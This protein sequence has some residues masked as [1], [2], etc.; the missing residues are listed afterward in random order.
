MNT[1]VCHK[2]DAYEI[3]FTPEGIIQSILRYTGCRDVRGE[4][5]DCKT[6]STELRRVIHK[7]LERKLKGKK[8]RGRSEPTPSEAKKLLGHLLAGDEEGEP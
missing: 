3:S 7:E 8:K 1:T 5:V 4:P 2:S 6:I